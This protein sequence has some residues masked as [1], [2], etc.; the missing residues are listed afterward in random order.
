[1]HSASRAVA[2]RAVAKRTSRRK[3]TSRPPTRP[4]DLKVLPIRSA[5]D[6]RAALA[7]AERLWDAKPG[8]PEWNALDVLATV[9]HAYEAEHYPPGPPDP[10]VAIRYHLEMSGKTERDLEGVIGTRARV[11]EIMNGK[12]KLTLAMIHALHDEFDIPV[13]SLVAA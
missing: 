12:R 1:M 10:V 7:Q 5:A 8:T 6:H 11:W 3:R 2:N 4:G 13:K 9:V